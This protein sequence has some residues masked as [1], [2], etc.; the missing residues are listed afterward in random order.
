ME[1][2]TTLLISLLSMF[3][4][5]IDIDKNPNILFFKS[6]LFKNEVS[7]SKIDMKNIDDLVNKRPNIWTF[8]K[9]V[10]NYNLLRKTRDYTDLS[11][12]QKK[13]NLIEYDIAD[14]KLK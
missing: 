10:E 6:M 2:I 7:V 9:L 1:Y 8:N 11:D 3:N 12:F 14:I 4:N 13:K 5:H